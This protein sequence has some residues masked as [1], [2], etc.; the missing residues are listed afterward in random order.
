MPLW[1]VAV[2]SLHRLGAHGVPGSLCSISPNPKKTRRTWTSDDGCARVYF[3][4]SETLFSENAPHQLQIVKKYQ[5][6]VQQMTKLFNFA[7]LFRLHFFGVLSHY[8]PSTMQ[9]CHYCSAS[10]KSCMLKSDDC[11]TFCGVCIPTA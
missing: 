6:I 10:A 8:H 9:Y 2:H 3:F 1:V 7:T 4:W 11:I 5:T